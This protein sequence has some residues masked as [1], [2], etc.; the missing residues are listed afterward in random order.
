MHKAVETPDQSSQTSV[1]DEVKV[2]AKP[3]RLPVDPG[4]RIGTL[5]NGLTYY[6]REHHKPEN[7]I[8]MRL[9][10]NAGSILEDEDQRGLAHFLEHMAFNG[11]KHFEK[12]ALIDYLESI[13]MQFGS[14]IN[15]YTS[16]EETVYMLQVPTDDAQ[17]LDSAFKILGDWANGILLESNEIEKERGVVLEEWRLGRGAQGR[18]QDKQ[19]PLMYQGSKFAERLPI[20]LP[21]VIEHAPQEAF[22]RFYRDWYR[23]D[24]MA[25]VVVGDLEVSEMETRIKTYFDGIRG[26]ETPRKRPVFD[27]PDHEG[28]LFSA[29]TDP[30]LTR[31]LVQILY[32]KDVEPFQ[33]EADLPKSFVRMLYSMILNERLQERAKESDPPF[34]MAY[35]G[36]S[37]MART[38][39]AF[40]QAAIVN[41]GQFQRGI[42]ALLHEAERVKRFGFTQSEL[43]RARSV[44]LRNLENRVIE[45]D[46]LPSASLVSRYVSHFLSPETSPIIADTVMLEYA[47][48]LL[49]NIEL[50]DL[51]AVTADTMTDDNR[52]I[53]MSGPEKEGLAMPTEAEV[54]AW[55]KETAKGELTAYKDD[56]LDAPLIPKIGEPGKVVSEEQ[57]DK[58]ITLWTL[59]NGVRVFLKPTDFYN[60]DISF[61]S[62]S[63]GGFSLVPDEELLHARIANE[64]TEKSGFG[65]FS[66]IQL[67]K[68]LAGKLAHAYPYIGNLFE[69]ISGS[70]SGKDLET[71]F[72]LI[73][74]KLT[75]PKWDETA[76]S[77]MKTQKREWLRNRLA[78]PSTV[79][80]DQ[81]NELYYDNHPR[82]QS[83]TLEDVDRLDPEKA[84]AYFKD[85]FAD[86]GDFT[87][88]FV[89][90]LE[91]EVIRPLVE[92]YLGSLPAVGRDESWKDTGV[93]PVKGVHDLT[94]YKGLED[95]CSVNIRFAG[96]LEWT[97]NEVLAAQSL[98]KVLRIRLREILREDKGGVY[99]VSVGTSVMRWP[100]GRFN[101]YIAFGCSPENADDLIQ[102]AFDE[103][104]RIQAEGVDETVLEKVRESFI[105][106]REVAVKENN[107][108]LNTI[109]T[110]DK[111]GLDLARLDRFEERV[112][113]IDVEMIQSAAKRFFDFENR[114]KAKLL[115]EK[116]KPADQE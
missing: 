5:E 10:V 104:M 44:Y 26:P 18:I 77:S 47:K 46:K 112:K 41:E 107:F 58:G 49:P 56:Q 109:S 25:V 91:L 86:C 65:A 68:K 13:G 93:R 57:L 111:F 60:D 29:E 51:Q 84:L 103:I 116:M 89:G 37:G 110:Y 17:K 102:A 106:Q 74:L 99:G 20:G 24:L 31:S 76:F 97:T 48:S 2:T 88:V 92:T 54:N 28:T 4:V 45:Q 15:A 108:W 55:I 39:G 95:K 16:F 33:S 19:F 35:S 1:S 83:M 36:F 78:N 105:R 50:A 27:V 6:V 63:P 53:L 75:A 96:E 64:I 59:E 38:K 43:D 71:L 21:E 61:S 7:R 69:G 8:E 42:E 90:N 66:Q 72:Q 101:S 14:D 73:H 100:Q 40:A 3:N 94:V 79:F 87:F 67:E 32:K 12:Q 80:Y 85:R 114:M 82:T 62:Y 115:P 30:E 9:V 113:G 23:P 34:L 70:C 11:T 22:E 81:M 98:S 52:I